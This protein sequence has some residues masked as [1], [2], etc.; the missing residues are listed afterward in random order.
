MTPSGTPPVDAPPAAGTTSPTPYQL[1]PRLSDDEYEALKADIAANGVRVPIDTDENGTILDGHHRAWITAD[2]G[3]E[4]PRRI[5]TGLSGDEK[6]AHAIAVNVH[7][8]NLTRDQRRDLVAKLRGDGMPVRK[9]AQTIGVPKSTVA[10]DLRDV[11]G[12]GHVD[13]PGTITDTLGRQQPA[14]RPR[15]AAPD[16]ADLIAGADWVQP[17]GPG[18]EDAVTP[19]PQP[20]KPKRRPLPEAFAETALDLAKTSERL[21]RLRQDDRFTRNRAHTHH[22]MPA[23][24][25]ALEHTTALIRDMDLGSSTESE[26]ARRWWA[27]SLH[28]TCDALTDVA[29]SLNQEQS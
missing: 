9:I 1:L 13:L 26:E 17:E 7:R 27:T 5:L 6:R 16:D 11:S 23:L 8:R 20:A 25:T 19:P 14:T 12:S 29:N 22:Q 2:L 21:D 24:I 15:T 3:I 4:C 18:F 10:D 28:K